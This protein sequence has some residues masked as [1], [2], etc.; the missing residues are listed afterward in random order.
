MG[1]AV[2]AMACWACAAS[3]V[4]V[5]GAATYPGALDA[6]FG[7]AGIASQTYPGAAASADLL[8]PSPTGTVIVGH[9]ATTASNDGELIVARVDASGAFD[10][11]YG[12][13]T[14]SD[15]AAWTPASAVI[16]PNGR[17]VVAANGTPG[18]RYPERVAL[19]GFDPGGHLDP[20]FG[21]AGKMLVAESGTAVKLFIGGDGDLHVAGATVT[22]DSD[23]TTGL[24]SATISPDG[25]ELSAHT[26]PIAGDVGLGAATPLPNGDV[27][28][29]GAEPE[30]AGTP[31]LFLTELSPDGTGDASFA[32]SGTVTTPIKNVQVDAVAV[33]GSGRILVAGAY[34]GELGRSVDTPVNGLLAR[35]EPDGAI[36]GSFAGGG[37]P[38]AGAFEFSSVTPLT[39]GSLLVTADGD[40]AH[41]TANG[42]P[43]LGF[44]DGGR[45]PIGR[46]NVDGPLAIAGDD[47]QA[48][49]FL[50]PAH[51][52]DNA[53]ALSQSSLTGTG[54]PSPVAGSTIQVAPE[55]GRIGI[56]VQL[57]PRAQALD[58]PTDALLAPRTTDIGDGTDYA[59]YAAQIRAGSGRVGLVG[60]GGRATVT[61][62]TFSLR[63]VPRRVAALDLSSPGCG[64][65]TIVRLQGPFTV[66]AGRHSASNASR[67]ATIRVSW[68]CRR[69]PTIHALS[70]RLTIKRFH[71][72]P[73]PGGWFA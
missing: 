61:G 46:L 58:A 54:I 26:V 11:T 5:A 13:L 38:S 63:T 56:R 50:Y 3:A 15:G 49:G 9:T 14:S 31:H 36:D 10:P 29:A 72:Q 41:L 20:S 65:R 12:S 19:F 21:A 37:A 23:L 30:G 59:P 24:L 51:G 60:V 57:A 55:H 71:G 16:E 7:D 42:E 8:L 48:P 22:D 17:L 40:L 32:S 70:G 43:E 53:L 69:A 67:S 62:G 18:G 6:S 33:D 1:T 27:L 66:T 52:Y 34:L 68:P 47:V 44:G 4:P 25:Q 64:G 28:F 39:D 35:F 73:R 45:A 2:A